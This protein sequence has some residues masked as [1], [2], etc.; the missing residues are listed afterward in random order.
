MML[1]CS[2]DQDCTALEKN[3]LYSPEM[4]GFCTVFL[5]TQLFWS[6][7]IP[8]MVH[9]ALP[10]YCKSKQI[11]FRR[12]SYRMVV[13]C[14]FGCLKA[15]WLCQRTCL[16]VNIANVVHIT[17]ACSALHNIYETREEYFSSKWTQARFRFQSLNR[18]P[19]PIHVHAAPGSWS[20]FVMRFACTLCISVKP[21]D[22]LGLC[23]RTLLWCYGA[24]G[25]AQENID[26]WETNQEE[27][28]C[29]LC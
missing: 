18:Q 9:E 2:W 26:K 4:I 11:N 6:I 24:A 17:M 21:E 20:K 27:T 22:Y 29:I 23:Q 14:T 13:E 28:G 16:D 25:K 3:G 7:P 12:S 15:Y 10:W 1:V 8:T 19:D 5:S